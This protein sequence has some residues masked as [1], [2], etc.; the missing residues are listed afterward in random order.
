MAALIHDPPQE[1][2]QLALTALKAL[3]SSVRGNANGT[4]AAVHLTLAL[5]GAAL[6]L[7]REMGEL[8]DIDRIYIYI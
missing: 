6:V 5:L 3:P 4:A 2:K 8:L 1:A 7:S